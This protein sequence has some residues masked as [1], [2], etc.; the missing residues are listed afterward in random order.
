MEQVL[1]HKASMA[2][3]PFDAHGYKVDRRIRSGADIIVRDVIPFLENEPVEEL[4][5][6]LRDY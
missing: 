1:D 2:D 3:G 6:K 4:I 5:Q